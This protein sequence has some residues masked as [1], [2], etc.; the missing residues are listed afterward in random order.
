MS[1]I[2]K[3]RHKKTSTE[4]ADAMT[5]LFDTSTDLLFL[6]GNVLKYQ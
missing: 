4:A 3:Y 2:F 1:V 6:A 5:S